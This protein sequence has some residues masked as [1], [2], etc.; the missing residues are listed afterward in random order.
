MFWFLYDLSI[1]NAFILYC[2]S[3]NHA[4]PQ[5]ASGHTKCT[6]LNFRKELALELIGRHT[7]RKQLGRPR[8]HIPVVS[9]NANHYPTI[10]ESGTSC[11]YCCTKTPSPG[12]TAQDKNHSKCTKFGCE[13]CKLHM[14]V[15]CFK[16]YHILTFPDEFK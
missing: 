4:L 13:T 5:T 6:H 15:P 10:F 8:R 11:V 2:E 1:Q 3:P 14:C 12:D 9:P 7:S 16:P